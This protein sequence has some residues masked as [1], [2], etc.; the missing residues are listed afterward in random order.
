MNVDLNPESIAEGSSESITPRTNA[1]SL[2][3][4]LASIALVIVGLIYF[5]SIIKPFVI[6]FLLWF[7]IDQL[8]KALGKIGWN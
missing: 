1:S 6:A 8:K 4:S 5:S 7:I 2:F 3:Y